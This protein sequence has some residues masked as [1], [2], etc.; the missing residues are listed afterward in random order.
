MQSVARALDARPG[1]GLGPTA[2]GFADMNAIVVICW[3]T[4][5][6]LA[7]QSALT[8]D[9]ADRWQAAE[10]IVYST[11]LQQVST[12]KTRIE[13][14]FSPDVLGQLKATAEHDLTVGGPELAAHAVKVGL[15]DEFQLFLT[16]IVAGGGKHFFPNGIRVQLD[17]LEERR[18]GNGTIYLRYRPAG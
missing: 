16:P 2:L 15:V 5:P 12:G 4:D 9:F 3:E 6:T 1:G 17:L 18:F 11:T 14:T 8:R 7:A 10:K 13:R